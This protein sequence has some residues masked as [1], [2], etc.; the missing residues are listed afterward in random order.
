MRQDGAAYALVQFSPYVGQ[1]GV[2]AGSG[3]ADAGLGYGMVLGYRAI[4]R[5]S[6]S[7]ALEVSHEASVHRNSLAGTASHANRAG[8]G[9]RASLHSDEKLQP[10]VSAGAALYTL[11]F[12]DMPTKFDLSGPGAFVAGGVDYSFSSRFTARAELS[13]GLWEAADETGG[14]GLAATITLG[15]GAAFSF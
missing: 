15:T 2:L 14:G 5:G 9:L 11:R 13:L 4:V 7:V 12:D 10:F 8:L 3:R 1:F 6:T